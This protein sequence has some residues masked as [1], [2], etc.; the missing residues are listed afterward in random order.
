MHFPFCEK[1]SFTY[2]GGLTSVAYLGPQGFT[3]NSAKNV[4]RKIAKRWHEMLTWWPAIGTDFDRRQYLVASNATRPQLCSNRDRLCRLRPTKKSPTTRIGR[5]PGR[6]GRRERTAVLRA[7]FADTEWSRKRR[8]RRS[9]RLTSVRPR[10]TSTGRIVRFWHSI[11]ARQPANIAVST[12]LPLIEPP[13]ALLEGG[14]LSEVI[15]HIAMGFETE[16][17]WKFMRRNLQEF[18]KFYIGL[19]YCTVYWQLHIP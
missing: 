17:S 2:R 11:V 4:P 6:W 15:R 12:V 10:W 8:D 14:A 3:V 5:K 19:I 18:N 9:R 1:I 16:F 7:G 13:G